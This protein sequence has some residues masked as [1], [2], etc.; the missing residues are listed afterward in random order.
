MGM[1]EREQGAVQELYGLN[2]IRGEGMIEGTNKGDFIV[3]NLLADTVIGRDG[4][5]EI[6]IFLGIDQAY[7]EDGDDTIQGGPDG[8]QLFVQNGEDNIVGGLDDDLGVG[9]PGDDHLFGGPGDDQL[10]GN[11]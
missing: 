3:G 4:S 2:I 11:S 6:Q 1:I 8:D 7:A 9:G 10:K 5:D